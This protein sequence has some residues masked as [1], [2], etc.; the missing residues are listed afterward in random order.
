MSQ[1][2]DEAEDV[3]RTRYLQFCGRVAGLERA[4]WEWGRA[5]PRSRFIH[6]SLGHEAAAFHVVGC[7]PS[8]RARWALYYRSH[9][10]LLALG[11]TLADV[12]AEISGAGPSPLRGEAGP[13]HLLLHPHVVDCNSIVGAQI[14]VAVGTALAQRGKGRPTVCVMGDGATNTGVFFEALNI[15]SL[16]RAPVLFVVEDNGVAM[17]TPYGRTSAASIEAKFELFSIPF[18]HAESHDIDSS[19]RAV[20]AAS[21]L[22]P[23]GPAAVCISGERKGPHVLSFQDAFDEAFVGDGNLLREAMLTT[24]EECA[25]LLCLTPSTRMGGDRGNEH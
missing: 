20:A 3:Y 14:P 23:E 2:I 18:F 9:A 17:D 21:D 22:A 15:A 13:M 10:W 7:I 11:A 12:V 16:Y 1:S 8:E 19:L 25:R 24:Y 6:A 5:N 4:L